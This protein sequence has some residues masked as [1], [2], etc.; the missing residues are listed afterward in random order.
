MSNNLLII[1]M[2]LRNMPMEATIASITPKDAAMVRAKF[3]FRMMLGLTPDAIAVSGNADFG[4]L[5]G[6]SIHKV[7]IWG[8]GDYGVQEGSFI[9][10]G[11]GYQLGG[12][13]VLTVTRIYVLN[14]SGRPIE[15]KLSDFAGNRTPVNTNYLFVGACVAISRVGGYQNVFSTSV[16]SFI[17]PSTPGHWLSANYG[18]S[19]IHEKK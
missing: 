5:F 3:Y 12:S 10:F 8:P 13:G 16:S 14:L 15:Y 9:D 6:G 19:E 18:Q 1:L 7:Y 4:F 11:L 17:G 2:R